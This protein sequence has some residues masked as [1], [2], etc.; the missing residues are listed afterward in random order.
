[1]GE[2]VDQ[3]YVHEDDERI[4][5]YP[6]EHRHVARDYARRQEK[7]DRL[8]ARPYMVNY[9]INRGRG[10]KTFTKWYRTQLGARFDAFLQTFGATH[11]RYTKATMFRKGRK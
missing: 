7:Q 11:N 9:E 6:V 4:V 5:L 2:V 1:V 10:T 3:P 8:E